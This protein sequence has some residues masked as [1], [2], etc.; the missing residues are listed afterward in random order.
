[1][2]R[3]EIEIDI[4]EVE[5]LAGLGLTQEEIALSLGIHGERFPHDSTRR[6]DEIS[7]LT[8]AIKENTKATWRQ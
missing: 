4:A 6:K 7:V 5:R 2:G 1:M 8:D 3:K